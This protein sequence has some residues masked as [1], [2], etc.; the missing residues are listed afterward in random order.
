MDPMGP[1]GAIG[2]A[3]EATDLAVIQSLLLKL[4]DEI[5]IQAPIGGTQTNQW[6]AGEGLPEI[7]QQV[8]GAADATGDDPGLGQ[9]P[10]LLGQG[11]GFGINDAPATPPQFPF[12]LV[13]AGHKTTFRRQA[14]SSQVKPFLAWVRNGLGPMAKGFLAN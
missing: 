1:F 14:G 7:H 13:L 2:I 3:I 4:V 8:H 9:Q 5:A 10:Q 12:Q 11:Q 6:P